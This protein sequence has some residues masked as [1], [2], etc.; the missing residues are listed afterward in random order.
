MI[1]V[2]AADVCHKPR[3]SLGGLEVRVALHALRVAH[4]VQPRQAL[5]LHMAGRTRRAEELVGLVSRRLMTAQAGIIGNGFP[6][7]HF[8]TASHHAGVADA[9]LVGKEGV[10]RR[11]LSLAVEGLPA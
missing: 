9:A 1:T 3:T 6:E 11:Q 2:E 7:T 4:V 8:K 5:V 10:R